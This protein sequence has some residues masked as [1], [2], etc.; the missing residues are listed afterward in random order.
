MIQD[1][2]HEF[3]KQLV[4]SANLILTIVR[5]SYFEDFGNCGIP[6]VR[7]GTVPKC[8]TLFIIYEYYTDYG[9]KRINNFPVLQDRD[10]QYTGDRCTS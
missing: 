2:N 7:Y 1:V 9:F 8:A 10:V 6:T 3:R 4:T 5:K